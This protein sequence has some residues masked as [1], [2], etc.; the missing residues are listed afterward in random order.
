MRHDIAYSRSVGRFLLWSAALAAV[1]VGLVLG[2]VIQIT[3]S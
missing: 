1:M 2:L 3:I